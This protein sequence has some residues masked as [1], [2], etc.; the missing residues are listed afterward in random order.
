MTKII[1]LS[2]GEDQRDAVHKVVEV[3]SQGGLVAVPTESSYAL[4]A[5][6]LKSDAVEKLKKVV[7][8][9]GNADRPKVSLAVKSVAEAE[10]YI[11][12]FGKIASR[13]AHRIWP[14]P[15]SMVVENSKASSNTLSSALPKTTLDAVSWEEGTH[16]W[17][18]SHLFLQE[19]QRLSA[20]PLVL[21]TLEQK[22]EQSSF[23]FSDFVTQLNGEIDL[24]VDAETTR[25]QQHPTIVSAGEDD[26]KLIQKGVVTETVIRRLAGEVVLFV[27]TGNTCRSPMAEALF[28]KMLSDRLGC[29]T[30]ELMD[31]GFIV[32]SAGI[33][34]ADGLPASEEA[35]ELLRNQKVELSSHESSQLTGDLL[36]QSDKIYTMTQ[37]H[38][39]VILSQRPDVADRAQLLSPEG[40][41]ISDPI[42]GGMRFYKECAK[43]IQDALEVLVAERNL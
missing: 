12:G 4:A 43:E 11:E 23:S 2:E 17:V 16:L 6:S 13:L 34:A 8:S 28:R 42:G 1:K 24:S 40:K 14:G 35:V 31:K 41:D 27:C 29:T 7:S 15:M 26:W 20:A 5:S 36:D 38:L 3:L 37:G 10:D 32:C 33:S 18:P 25:Y 19:V 9:S 39:Q 21:G 30:D 22:E